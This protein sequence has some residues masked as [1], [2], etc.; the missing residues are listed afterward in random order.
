MAR[1]LPI[2]AVREDL[3]AGNL[4]LEFV[5]KEITEP[6]EFAAYQALSE[7]HYRE[8][9]LHGRTARLVVRSFHPIYPKVVGYI[10]LAMPF[11]MNKPRAAI[12]D[13][14]FAADGITWDRWDIPTMRR[15]IHLIVRIGRCVIYPE[16]RGL[17]LGQALLK[18]AAAFARERWQVA[19]LKPYFLEISA[20]M[21]KYV[22]FAAR[23]GMTF[24]GETEGNLGRAYL[25]ICSRAP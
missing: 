25:N 3:Q 20:D 10:E 21:L 22:P 8:R 2:Y 24:V 13:A 7:F 14:P 18:H 4:I 15:Y 11:Y 17:G 5:I 16:F 9:T 23:A 12:L 19:A 6:D 1:I